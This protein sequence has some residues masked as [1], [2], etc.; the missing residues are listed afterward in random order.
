MKHKYLNVT[1]EMEVLIAVATWFKG[2]PDESLKELLDNI[3][4]HYLRIDQIKHVWK[5]FPIIHS[6]PEFVSRL[7]EEIL[8]KALIKDITEYAQKIKPARFCY[9]FKS[10][11]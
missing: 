9:K 6:N 5:Q 8:N 3:N 1:N 10:D 7:K 4:W 2:N 11:E